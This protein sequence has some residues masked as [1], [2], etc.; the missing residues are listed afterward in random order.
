MIHHSDEWTVAL[1]TDPTPVNDQMTFSGDRV[2][3]ARVMMK[4]LGLQSGKPIST[5]ARK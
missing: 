2:R 3:T 5:M 4:V 1:G